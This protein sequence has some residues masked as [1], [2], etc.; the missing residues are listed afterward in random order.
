M[1]NNIAF[2]PMGKTVLLSSTSSSSNVAV[3]ADSPVNQLYISNTGNSDVYLV[4]GSSTP[5]TAVKP[6]AGT[7]QYGFSIPAGTIKVG[8]DSITYTQFIGVGSHYIG[9]TAT[10]ISSAAA[11]DAEYGLVE[12][13][14][15]YSLNLYSPMDEPKTSSVEK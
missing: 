4:T 8:T 11:F 2:Q 10:Q 14:L 3:T 7:P 6:T 5:L 13:Y 15:S 1:A 12:L 9:T